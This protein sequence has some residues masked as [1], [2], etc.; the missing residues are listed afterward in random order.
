[1]EANP[2][3]PHRVTRLDTDRRGRADDL[4]ERGK[5]GAIE[6]EGQNLGA[7]PCEGD[8]ERT[9]PSTDLHDTVAGPDLRVGDDRACEVRVR[10]EVLAERLRRADP[11]TI[12]ELLQRGAPETS[13]TR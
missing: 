4:L 8:G 9:E 10:E 7:R 3:D 13:L 6:L 1:M 12:R 11:V 2:V 5:Q